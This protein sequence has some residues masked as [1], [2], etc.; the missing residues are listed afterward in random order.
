[1]CTWNLEGWRK[2]W[3]L[4]W[5][6]SWWHWGLHSQDPWTRNKRSHCK[7][8]REI[9]IVKLFGMSYETKFPNSNLFTINN[10]IVV[11]YIVSCWWTRVRSFDSVYL[12]ATRMALWARKS[13]PSTCMD[14]SVRMFLLRRRLKL[15][16]TSPAWRVNW[17]QSSAVVAM[18]S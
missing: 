1:M 7:T 9:V 17:M 2:P 15:S 14:T 6:L 12:Q 11:T 18:L 4:L 8:E 16:R 3:G 13:C 5:G 10:D